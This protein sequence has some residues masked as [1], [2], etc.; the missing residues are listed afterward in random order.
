MPAAAQRLASKKR[1]RRSPKQAGPAKAAKVK[2]KKGTKTRLKG[3]IAPRLAHAMAA[4]RAEGKLAGPRSQK[5][6][7]RL[8]PGLLKAAAA[9]TGIKNPTDLV[10]A[11]LALAAAPD[12]YGAWLVSRAGTLPDDFEF[13]F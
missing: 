2:A 1:T 4:L 3:W 5:L 12:N 13:D 7:V 11:A 6:G 10:T 8:Q 9:S